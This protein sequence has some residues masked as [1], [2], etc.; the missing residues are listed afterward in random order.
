MINHEKQQKLRAICLPTREVGQLLT[1]AQFDRLTSTGRRDYLADLSADA[2]FG[3][4]AVISQASGE[5]IFAIIARWTD[6][7]GQ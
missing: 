2:L 5:S 3:Q 4:A 1:A 6:E 7:A